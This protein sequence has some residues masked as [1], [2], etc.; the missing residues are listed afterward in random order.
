MILD[1]ILL[2]IGL[3]ITIAGANWLIDGSISLARRYH[4]SE[5]VIG[6]TIVAIGTSAPEL[7][8]TVMASF[9]GST[10][11]AVSNILGSNIANILL[12]LGLSSVVFPLTIKTSTKWKEIPFSLLAVVVLL[13]LVLDSRLN[14][15]GMPS[16]ISRADGIILL[17][18][19]AIF[20]VYSFEMM[21][22]NTSVG[23]LT[24]KYSLSKSILFIFLGVLALFG[25]GKTLVYGA[26]EFAQKAGISSRIIGLTIVAVGTSLPELIT[27]IV[28][29]FKKNSDIAVGNVVGSNIFNIFLVLGISAT[30]HPIDFPN[31]SYFDIAT[32]IFATLILFT[33]A[34]FFG[35]NII[36]RI[37][38]IFFLL[39]YGVYLSLL[40]I[41]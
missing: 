15:H 16:Q 39:L 6:L 1:F 12:I 21:R 3:L 31:S 29:A 38:G 11:L 27:S 14:Q 35:T 30:I 25:G 18:F 19:L 37:E 24:P 32:T 2:A 9:D 34:I 33:S 20:F 28:A 17:L 5:L 22:Q 23:D 10:D 7:V 36:R 26:T 4:V 13:V 41:L 40:I 8:V